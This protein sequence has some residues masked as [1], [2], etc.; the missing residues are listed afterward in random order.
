MGQIKRPATKSSKSSGA[1]GKTVSA[2]AK[3]IG[4]LG[5]GKSGGGHGRRRHGANYWANK[6][7]VAKLKKKYNRIQYGG[8]R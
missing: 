4:A 3:I 8:A 6:V 5:G 2:G 7:L 1:L